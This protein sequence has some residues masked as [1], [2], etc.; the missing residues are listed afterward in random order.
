MNGGG[1]RVRGR[2]TPQRGAGDPPGSAQPGH[3]RARLE[4]RGHPPTSPAT[5][6]AT[7]ASTAATDSTS[8]SAL[9]ASRCWR[10]ISSSACSRSVSSR[11]SCSTP[12]RSSRRPSMRCRGGG[13]SRTGGSTFSTPRRGPRCIFARRL[14]EPSTPRIRARGRCGFQITTSA[15]RFACRTPCRQR[16]GPCLPGSPEPTGFGPT[17]S[18]WSRSSRAAWA[19][20]SDVRPSSSRAPRL[21]PHRSSASFSGCTR[22]RLALNTSSYRLTGPA[23]RSALVD[24]SELGGNCRMLAG[25]TRHDRSPPRP[26]RPASFSNQASS[27]APT[28]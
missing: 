19:K 21:L 1:H 6:S 25:A 13:E 5:I 3:A 24:D 26:M 14:L 4:P 22:S 20:C 2:R 11:S 8:P 23:N 28:P 12:A 27:C 18:P 7:A 15:C 17:G 10:S 16:S 9:E